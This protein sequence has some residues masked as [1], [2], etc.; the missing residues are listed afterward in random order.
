MLPRPELITPR[1]CSGK[2]L[3][4]PLLST[5]VY[6]TPCI[7]SATSCNGMISGIAYTDGVPIHNAAD[8]ERAAITR[9]IDLYKNLHPIHFLSIRTTTAPETILSPSLTQTSLTVPSIFERAA[10]I[11]PP[12]SVEMRTSSE[13]SRTSLPLGITHVTFPPTT[14]FTGTGIHLQSSPPAAVKMSSAAAK[15]IL[16]M[17]L[18][19]RS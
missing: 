5:T 9:F 1:T 10:A 3:S 14:A 15:Y 6:S 19:S 18:P 8:T 4:S 12:V 17:V 13:P 2:L 16:R 11:S 7:P